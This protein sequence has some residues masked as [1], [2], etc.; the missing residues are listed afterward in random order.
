[1]I[2]S[3]NWKPRRTSAHVCPVPRGTMSALD[4]GMS[5]FWAKRGKTG[6]VRRKEAFA[7][8]MKRRRAKR[9]WETSRA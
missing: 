6:T 5:A 1:M 8:M 2:S 7:A 3:R 9:L 4:R